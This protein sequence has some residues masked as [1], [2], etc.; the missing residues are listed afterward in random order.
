MLSW[1]VA[2]LSCMTNGLF[3]LSPMNALL[4]ICESAAVKISK[5]LRFA[6]LF[7]TVTCFAKSIL[8]WTALKMLF[9]IETLKA[10]SEV[11]VKTFKLQPL[12]VR[13]LDGLTS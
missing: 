2:L 9:K 12:I 10:L 8:N 7:D 6:T 1:T 3:E 5:L 4:L 11:K 13:L